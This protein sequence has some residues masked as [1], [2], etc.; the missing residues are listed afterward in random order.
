MVEGDTD[1]VPH[2][3]PLLGQLLMLAEK[4]KGSP[5]TELEVLEVRDSAPC[6]MLH[7]SQVK[8]MHADFR[9]VNPENCWADWHRVRVQLSE[10]AFLPR[11]VMC[12]LGN[13]ESKPHFE[14]VLNSE[15]IEHEFCDRDPR[16]REVFSA[17]YLE[18]EDLDEV[19]DHS[20]VLYIRSDGYSEPEAPEIAS[21]F[22]RVA[23]KLLEAG[24]V[25]LKCDSSGIAH[26][27]ARWLELGRTCDLTVLSK[28]KAGNSE[29]AG[30][31]WNALLCAYVQVRIYSPEAFYSCGMHLLGYPDVIVSKSV[32]QS[33]LPDNASLVDSAVYLFSAFCIY[34]LD[35]CPPGQ[36]L[37]GN[38]FQ[39]DLDFPTFRVIWEPCE[40]FAEDD[41]YFNPYG[42]WRFASLGK[43]S[44]LL[45]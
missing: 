29:L 2:F 3:V 26:S 22:L 11:I 21:R 10:Q 17:L 32:L 12:L 33:A 34:L 43:N 19:K 44:G 31:F 41:L 40:D 39:P 9:D 36:F 15:N 37:S 25:A 42:R 16:M 27:R 8:D 20:L 13:N 23:C 4:D 24:A 45:F 30:D 7:R 5:L 28:G 1:L 6:I 14:C 38:T 18:K 35:E